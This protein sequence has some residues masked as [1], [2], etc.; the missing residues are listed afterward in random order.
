MR[1]FSWKV[2]FKPL[3]PDAKFVI[4]SK[5]FKIKNIQLTKAEKVRIRNIPNLTPGDIKA[6]WQRHQF[7][8]QPPT[9]HNYIINELIS[10]VQYKNVNKTRTIGF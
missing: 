5:Y 1:R 6:V 8:P 7:A 10:E 2:E 4:Y 3:L 9:G